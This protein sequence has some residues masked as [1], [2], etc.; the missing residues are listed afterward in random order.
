VDLLRDR[1][2]DRLIHVWSFVTKSHHNYSIYPPITSR[3]G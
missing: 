1:K 3:S 2:R